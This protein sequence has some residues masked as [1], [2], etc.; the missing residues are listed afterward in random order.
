MRIGIL[1]LA[2][3]LSG[4]TSVA[5]RHAPPSALDSAPPVSL[6]EAGETPLTDLEIARI[7]TASTQ[8]PDR[9]RIALLYLDHRSTA[10]SSGSWMTQSRGQSRKLILVDESLDLLL[11]DPR[12][13][14]VS[15]LPTFLLPEEKSIGLIREAAA[16]YQADCVLVFRTETRPAAKLK[17]LGPEEAHA[18]CVAECALI[19][20]RTGIIPFTSTAHRTVT[21]V[22][23]EGDWSLEETM[24]RAEVEAIEASMSENFA[25]LITFFARPAN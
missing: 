5:T 15:Y 8:L 12:V 1:V 24:A 11:R 4:C 7:L 14:D 2:L 21:I 6:L 22:E 17:L 10:T 23:E 9:M 18:N 19:D 16:R 13:V 3:F 25:N 20:V